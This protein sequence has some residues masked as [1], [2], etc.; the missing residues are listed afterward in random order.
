M[1]NHILV[2]FDDSKYSNRAFE[3]AINLAKKHKADIT[4]VTVMYSSVL[5]SSFLDA[6]QHQKT[7]D[8]ERIKKMEY[9]FKVMNAIAEKY[10]ISLRTEVM[11]RTSV[12][13][14][15]LSISSVRDIDLIIMGTRG[16]GGARVLMLGSVAISVSQSAPCPVMLI[17]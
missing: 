9:T 4:V 2:P 15:I 13:E 5:G 6:S 14:A 16:R 1:I 12:A 7:F 11:M 8:R 3:Y 10:G 17:K